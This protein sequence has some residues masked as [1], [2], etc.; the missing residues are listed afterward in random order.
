MYNSHRP[1][2]GV[3]A[4]A[5]NTRL[6]ELLDQV[7][8]EFEGQATRAVDYEQQRMFASA[9]TRRCCM[10]GAI[11]QPSAGSLILPLQLLPLA[12][13][14]ALLNLHSTTPCNASSYGCRCGESC[15]PFRCSI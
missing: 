4:P 5:P 14:N 6:N 13:R 11:A 3:P 2:I 7:R 10:R 15:L 1:P 12:L 8:A 9:I